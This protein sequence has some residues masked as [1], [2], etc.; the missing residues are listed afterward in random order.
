MNST[1]LKNIKMK[2]CIKLLIVRYHFIIITLSKPHLVCTL[3]DTSAHT[4]A[5]SLHNVSC[6]N[7]NREAV[8]VCFRLAFY[9]SGI[10]IF[11]GNF[12]V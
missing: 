7:N 4:L 11:F 5:R 3:F 6:A 10:R 2:I 9:A 1:P 12:R 8:V